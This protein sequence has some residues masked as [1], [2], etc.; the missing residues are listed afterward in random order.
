MG[1]I[2]IMPSRRDLQGRKPPGHTMPQRT[3]TEPEITSSLSRLPISFSQLS[4]CRAKLSFSILLRYIPR[5]D[6]TISSML[7][8]ILQLDNASQRSFECCIFGN[9]SRIAFARQRAYSG[10]TEEVT[11]LMSVIP[12]YPRRNA[13]YSIREISAAT[14]PFALTHLSRS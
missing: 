6:S 9:G 14:F 4:L 1:L 2:Q 12:S 13:G 3:R 11:Q 10:N 8:Y 5:T 7:S